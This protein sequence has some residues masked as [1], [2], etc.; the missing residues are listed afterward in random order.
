M[1]KTILK[2][3]SPIILTLLLLAGLGA[4]FP[5][6]SYATGVSV[7]PSSDTVYVGDSVTV[8]VTIYGDE[9]YAYSGSVGCDGNLSG[10]TGGFADGA[11]GGGAVSFSYTY[12]A[13]G[14]GTAGVYVSNCEVSDGKTKDLPYDAACY[15]NVIGYD[16]GGGGTGGNAGGGWDDSGQINGV[17]VGEGSDNTNL[18]TLEVEGYTLTDEGHD[19]YSVSVSSSV[20][21]INIIAVP[22]DANAVVVGAGE[23]TLTDGENQFEIYVYAE[24]GFVRD[25]VIKVNRRGDKI[26]LADLEK[27]LK[28][29]KEDTLIVSLQD[30]D[31]ITKEMI[32]A[33]TKW[34]KTVKLNRYDA[35]GKLL[36]GW[37]M[38]GKDM[39]ELKTFQTF[40]PTVTFE[41]KNADKIETLSNYAS[42]KVLNFAYSGELPK[43]TVFTIAA[44]KDFTKEDVLYLYYYDEKE[45]TLKQEGQSV[46]VKGDEIEL[47]ITHCSEYLLTR[48][49]LKALEPVKQGSSR[50]DLL[51][52][53][54]MAVELAVIIILAVILIRRRPKP[55]VAAE[56]S[57]DHV[58]E[59]F[60]K[61]DEE[62][63]EGDVHEITGRHVRK[64]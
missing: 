20:K 63:H 6:K 4:G 35:D 3:I 52:M 61:T 29:T 56:A 62:V 45:N 14:E 25:Y 60:A 46:T 49:V 1:K 24:N 57:R 38:N 12:Y 55:A 17:E 11:D 42:G 50:K 40:D 58:A 23:Q 9:I 19:I 21:T 34:G 43:N 13:V 37:T 5:I 44:G 54:A 28:E 48:S 51:M 2:K 18:A 15:I 53:I 41:S 33:I 26:A 8:T 7:Y 10:F 39:A 64:R 27:E 32:A 47:A 30:G 31:K 59:M 36:Y 16:N 22:E